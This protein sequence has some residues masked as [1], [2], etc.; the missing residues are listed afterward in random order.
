[1]FTMEKFRAWQLFFHLAITSPAV[2]NV[3]T[4]ATELGHPSAIKLRSDYCPRALE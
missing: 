2:S 1:M 3:I 4:S